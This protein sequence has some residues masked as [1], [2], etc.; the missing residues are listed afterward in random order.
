C[1]LARSASRVSGSTPTNGARNQCDDKENDEDEEENLRD[2]GRRRGDSAEPEDPGDQ[3]DHQ[4]DK[5]PVKHV[6]PHEAV[7]V[8]IG[9]ETVNTAVGSQVSACA[10][11]TARRINRGW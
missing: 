8:A 7:A 5:G 10:S 6:Y 2:T 9:W 4:K 3:R 1:L 11:G